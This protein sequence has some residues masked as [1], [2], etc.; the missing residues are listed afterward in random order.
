MVFNPTRARHSYWTRD[1]VGTYVSF[2]EMGAVHVAAAET[3]PFGVACCAPR[4]NTSAWSTRSV[5]G[6]AAEAT[7]RAQTAGLLPVCGCDPSTPSCSAPL[8]YYNY[9]GGLFLGPSQ[10]SRFSVAQFGVDS[11]APTVGSFRYVQC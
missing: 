3:G 5:F 4:W 1:L 2:D 11:S 10:G 7:V 8:C 9:F 6:G